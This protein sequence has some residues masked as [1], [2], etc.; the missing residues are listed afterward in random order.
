MTSKE[1]AFKMIEG[2]IDTMQ[3]L[4]VECVELIYNS[5]YNEGIETA[6]RYLEMNNLDQNG[7]ADIIEVR[8]LKK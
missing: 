2:R 3:A 4:A 7:N 1:Q 5:A 8:K 6:A